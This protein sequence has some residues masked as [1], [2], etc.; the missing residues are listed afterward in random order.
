LLLWL[1]G[2]HDHAILEAY[3]AAVDTIDS[4][5]LFARDAGDVLDRGNALDRDLLP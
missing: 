3:R 4:A 5:E 2:F 1:L